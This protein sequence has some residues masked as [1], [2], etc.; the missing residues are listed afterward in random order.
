VQDF[1]VGGMLGYGKRKK[2]HSLKKWMHGLV[3]L[4]AGHMIALF[5]MGWLSVQI[6]ST[7][8]GL[9]MLTVLVGFI[10]ALLSSRDFLS[11]LRKHRVL[12]KFGN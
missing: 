11:A 9:V 4:M 1:A 5:M 6:L 2:N 10:L 3:I 12:G 7:L 8:G